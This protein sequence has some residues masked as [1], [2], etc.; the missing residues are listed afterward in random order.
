MP[1]HRHIGDTADYGIAVDT[2][3][4]AAWTVPLTIIEQIAEH[5]RGQA[6][7]GGVGDR[8]SEFDG[9]YDRVGNNSS[10]TRRRVRHRAPR[11]AGM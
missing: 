2:R 8:H 5:H 10:G 1:V 7:H 11:V 4:A 6:V 3:S 9:A